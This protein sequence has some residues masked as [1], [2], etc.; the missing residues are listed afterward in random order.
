MATQRSTSPERT[1]HPTRRRRQAV[2]LVVALALVGAACGSDSDSS[3]DSE[4]SFS[5]TTIAPSDRDG[6]NSGVIAND[7]GGD[8]EAEFDTPPESERRAEAPDD[9][10]DVAESTDNGGLFGTR[11]AVEDEPAPSVDSRFTDYGIRTFAV[12]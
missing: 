7:D 10:D 1:I 5:Q 11:P 3:A 2:A 8:A 12:P 6:Q 4:S 9:L